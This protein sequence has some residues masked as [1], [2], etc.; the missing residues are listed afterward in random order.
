MTHLHQT[1]N[2]HDPARICGH[3]G[4]EVR[5]GYAVCAACGANYRR[6]GLGIFIPAIL[7]LGLANA[8]ATGRWDA[9]LILVILLVWL[10]RR[11]RQYMWYRRNV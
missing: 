2:S 5:E 3:C 6:R 11:S 7:A 4:T 1:Y 9:T 8:A 10:I